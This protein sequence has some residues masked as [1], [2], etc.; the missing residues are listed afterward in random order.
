MGFWDRFLFATSST[1]ISSTSSTTAAVDTEIE[2]DDGSVYVKNS[3][4]AWEKSA[5]TSTTTGGTG[6]MDVE[7]RT[8][9]GEWFATGA[10]RHVAPSCSSSGYKYG[11]NEKEMRQNQLE[12]TDLY[13]SETGEWVK[14][15]ASRINTDI[16]GND[17]FSTKWEYASQGSR[18]YCSCGC[19]GCG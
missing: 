1:T 2:K 7:L 4:G 12:K 10:T 19:G 13:N 9:L 18:I 16:N 5:S 14:E 15:G 11:A 6:G 8:G 3:K 17:I